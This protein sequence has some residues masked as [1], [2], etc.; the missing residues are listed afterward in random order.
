MQLTTAE[1][2]RRKRVETKERKCGVCGKP[3]H[4]TRTC[5]EAVDTS[6]EDESDQIEL[7]WYVVVELFD[8][9]V[10]ECQKVS[11]SVVYPVR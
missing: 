11:R 7:I 2:G 5:K 10:A 4:N 9:F 3:G 1:G 8:F 6:S